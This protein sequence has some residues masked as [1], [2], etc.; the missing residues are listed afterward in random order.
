MS[1][2]ASPALGCKQL[3]KRVPVSRGR[4]EEPDLFRLVVVRKDLVIAWAVEFKQESM[5]ASVRPQPRPHDV[6]AAQSTASREGDE[7][8]QAHNEESTFMHVDLSISVVVPGQHQVLK[9]Q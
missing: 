3:S 9:A 7:A 2:A 4:G 6:A 5:A 1:V 8:L